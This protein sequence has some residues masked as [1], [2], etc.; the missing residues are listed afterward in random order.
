MVLPVVTKQNQQ[1]KTQQ[2]QTTPPPKTPTTTQSFKLLFL[3]HTLVHSEQTGI[4]IKAE[5]QGF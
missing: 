3:T 1:Q 4:K 2:K 5:M